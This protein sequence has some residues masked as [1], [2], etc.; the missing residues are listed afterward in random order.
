MNYTTDDVDDWG[1]PRPR[2]EICYRGQNTFKGYYRQSE[3]MKEAVDSNGWIRS[4]DIA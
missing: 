4:G 1:L 3:L 2:G